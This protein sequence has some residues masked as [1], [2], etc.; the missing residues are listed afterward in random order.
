MKTY[1]VR[2]RL[3][4]YTSKVEVCFQIL[5]FATNGTATLH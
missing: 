2:A 5:K 4:G 1:L 3:K